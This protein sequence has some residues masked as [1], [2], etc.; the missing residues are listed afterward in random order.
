MTD[1]FLSGNSHGPEAA[2]DFN[3]DFFLLPRKTR[4]QTND[5]T[6]GIAKAREKWTLKRKAQLLR[7]FQ[8]LAYRY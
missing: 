2:R 6:G 3:G 8:R 7:L 4:H 1:I 5:T